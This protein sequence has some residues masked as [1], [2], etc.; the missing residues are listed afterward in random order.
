[1]AII[2]Q[3]DER[4]GFLV[5]PSW[6]APLQ[7]Y[8]DET[9]N[10]RRLKLSELGLNAP[11]NRTFAIAG[12][13]LKQG[14][15]LSGWD[16]LRKAMGIQQNAAE[17]KFELVA[18]PAYEA[19][20]GSRKLSLFLEWLIQSDILL[21]YSVLDTL[22]WSVLDIIESLMADDRFKISEVHKE[23]KNELYFAV[24]K[25]SKAFMALLHGFCYPNLKRSEV[26]PFLSCV[27]AF[28]NHRAPKNRSAT[29]KMFKDVLRHASK[30]PRLELAFLHDN[31]PGELI[32][33]F[34]VHFMHCLSVFKHASHVFDRETYIEK[35]MQHFEVRDGD[36]L[37]NYRFDD[38][39]NNVGIQMSDV[40]AGL[41]GRHFTY[42]QQHSVPELRN[43]RAQFS[44]RQLSNLDM[45]SE[46][47]HRSDDFSDG[48]LHS[49]CPL[50]T[51]Y[52]N[53]VFLHG[54]PA[55]SYLG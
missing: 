33:N 9:N 52:K 6:D 27:L 54:R 31:K 23:L 28:V 13:A 40:V 3:A 46:L 18:P 4:R 14:Q 44:A 43:A 51:A 39:K 55:P 45:L 29:M 11:A 8:Y 17:V 1:M 41:V 50:D 21:H 16:D 22:Y 19:A 32:D 42:V 12:I 2:I 48:L 25:D 35:I 34:C 49:L 38:S 20:L 30:T 5:Q 24:T 7:M 37:V 10:I 36:R 26:G 15:T 47:I 53:D